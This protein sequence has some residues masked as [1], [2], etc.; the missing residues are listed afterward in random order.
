MTTKTP[1]TVHFREGLVVQVLGVFFRI[2]R[3]KLSKDEMLLRKLTAAEVKQVE[4]Y[5]KKEKEKQI[6]NENKELRKVLGGSK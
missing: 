4:L 6:L 2:K 1:K 3:I 5:L